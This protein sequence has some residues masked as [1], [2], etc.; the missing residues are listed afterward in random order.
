MAALGLLELE[1]I[2]VGIRVGD[3]V[4]KRA[5]V[6]HLDAGT[7][8]PGRYLVL[9]RGDTATVEEAMDAGREAAA[10]ALLDEIFLPDPHPHVDAALSG[11]RRGRGAGEALG[12]VETRTVAAVLGAADRGVK[13]ARVELRQIRIADDLGGKAYCLFEGAVGDVEAAV[14]L[15]VAGLVRPE[16]LVS[17]VVIPRLHEEMAGSLDSALR[18][19]PHLGF[20]RRVVRG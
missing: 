11:A 16:A 8:H 9:V 1:S 2:A 7:V 10:G 20:E 13:G 5:P 3:A 12:V 18:F 4:V 19:L 17:Q 15:A 6:D 14:E